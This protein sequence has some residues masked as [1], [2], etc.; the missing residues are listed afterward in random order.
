[1]VVAALG[2]VCCKAPVCDAHGSIVCEC[3]VKPTPPFGWMSLRCR[4]TC[5]CPRQ[6]SES[7]S[8]LEIR[9]C[10][11]HLLSGE[12]RDMIKRECSAQPPSQSRC[13]L[14]LK[15]CRVKAYGMYSVGSCV[16]PGVAVRRG[17][18]GRGSRSAHD[19][20][21]ESSPFVLFA[22]WSSLTR[23]GCKQQSRES[24]LC[25]VFRQA[26]S[27]AF[28]PTSSSYS[29]F[30]EDRTTQKQTRESLSGARCFVVRHLASSSLMAQCWL[31][32]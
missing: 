18:A 4:G 29:P 8:Q 17:R 11:A 1:M 21:V 13:K 23:L 15:R 26:S 6:R 20:R 3:C 22:S 30:S 5:R 16:V 10:N 32:T 7:F 9:S 19:A 28:S 27:S 14:F 31:V 2:V 24:V 12:A 25:S